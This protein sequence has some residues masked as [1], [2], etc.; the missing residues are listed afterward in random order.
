M[1]DKPTRSEATAGLPK[2]WEEYLNSVAAATRFLVLANAGG[3]VAVLS[4]MG[5]A[6]DNG[7]VPKFA[8]VPLLLFFIGTVSAGLELLSRMPA[9]LEDSISAAGLDGKHRQPW[10]FF[11]AHAAIAGTWALP[12]S[13]GLFIAG[14][15]TGIVFLAL[16]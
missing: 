12:L 5:A 8:L 2:M 3:S 4:F 10:R 6:M 9:L 14:G 13:F 15:V 7:A 16:L 1:T 11:T